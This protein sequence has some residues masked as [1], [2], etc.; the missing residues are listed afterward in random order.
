MMTFKEWWLDDLKKRVGRRVFSKEYEHAL[1]A[2]KGV[3]TRKTDD[4]T[5]R[6]SLEYYAAQ[7]ARTYSKVNARQLANYYKEIQQQGTN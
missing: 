7:I 2:L 5:K 1:N 3:M 4:G 6:H